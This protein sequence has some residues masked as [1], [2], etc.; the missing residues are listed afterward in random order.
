MRVRG[1]VLGIL[2]CPT[3]LWAAEP[4]SE[5]EDLVSA[6]EME[7]AYALA[8]QHVDDLAGNPQFDLYYGIAAVETGRVD[9]AIFAFERVLIKRPR[10]D[11]ARIELA[12][13]YFIQK[14]DRKAREQFEIVLS[15]DPPPSVVDRVER[16]LAALNRRSDRYEPHFSG[17]VE[18]GAGR[19]DNVNR[20]SEEATTVRLFGAP[21]EIGGDSEPVS[22][23]FVDA[24]GGVKLSW[25]IE[26]GVNVTSGVSGDLRRHGERTAF[27]RERANARLG[28]RYREDAHRWATTIQRGWF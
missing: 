6:G 14:E 10:M 16:F 3:A 19:D 24:K 7:D 22:D 4:L 5:L 20:V 17:H 1:L 21:F 18:L 15:N 8:S 13:A 26:P 23:N 2:L 11:R 25:P 27:D 28:L 12:R 9:E